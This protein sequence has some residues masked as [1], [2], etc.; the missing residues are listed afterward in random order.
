MTRPLVVFA[1]TVCAF[2]ALLSRPA[3]AVD[4][5]DV[6]AEVSKPGVKLLVVEFFADWCEPCKKAAPKWN[7]LHKDYAKQGLRFVV[8]S[9]N[10]QGMCANPGWNPDKVLCDLDGSLQKLWQVNKLPQAFLFSWQGTRLVQNGHYDQVEA[11]VK[12]YLKESLRIT[13]SPPQDENGQSLPDSDGLRDRVRVELAKAGKFDFVASD[14]ERDTLRKLRQEGMNPNYDEKLQCEIGKELSANSE[15]KIRRLGQGANWKL[16]L[17]L[18]SVERGCLVASGGANVTSN[19]LDAA[20]TKASDRLWAALMGRKEQVAKDEDRPVSLMVWRIERKGGVS[21]QLVD[22]LS[23]VISAEAQRATGYLVI[24]ET[25][26]TTAIQLQEKRKKC[27]SLDDT[28][29]TCLA[30]V[31][32]VLKTSQT[33]TGDLGRFGNYWV[34]NLRLMEASRAEVLG[35]VSKRIK[36][37]TTALMEAAPDAVSE[38]FG[39]TV[40]K[41]KAS[42]AKPAATKPSKQP[43]EKAPAPPSEPMSELNKA[44]FATFFV[45]AG[46]IC[47]GGLAQYKMQKARDAYLSDPSS[48]NK[49]QFKGWKA[50]AIT[51]YT[52]GAASILTGVSLWIV[53]GV[54]EHPAKA[55]D[56]GA[57]TD[58]TPKLSLG[59]GPLSGGAAVTLLGRF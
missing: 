5:L 27:S 31:A 20:V 17:E 28:S 46:L 49:H 42:E 12:A 51:S 19:G 53:D 11:A 41:Q 55:P 8:V 13:I 23:G 1:L 34:L 48:S 50:G 54:R 38:L 2:W 24:S 52:L 45:G 26:I 29:D 37:D 36:G 32:K 47:F 4:A 25:D 22:T 57:K 21:A 39:F 35:R 7:K 56:A 16:L 30:E 58:K 44:G 40:S 59:A 14:K 18:F 3:Q 6:Q 43:K 9:V 10:E 33:L 15:L